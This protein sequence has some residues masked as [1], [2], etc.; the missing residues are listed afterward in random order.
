[1]APELHLG[2]QETYGLSVDIYALGMVFVELATRQKAAVCA[3]RS[4]R[5]CFA[6]DFDDVRQKMESA[7]TPGSFVEL[8]VQCLGY[9]DHE[10]PESE[11]V[12][13]WLEELVLE[14]D[15]QNKAATLEPA[16]AARTLGGGGESGESDSGSV[17]SAAAA[18]PLR[19]HFVQGSAGESETDELPKRDERGP[20]SSTSD[21]TDDDS[22]FAAA[23]DKP[24]PPKITLTLVDLQKKTSYGSD[25]D[26][27]DEKE[28][29]PS[30]P[31]TER[32]DD[33]LLDDEENAE[34]DAPERQNV[35]QRTKGAT[36]LALPAKVPP[37]P[38]PKSKGEEEEEAQQQVVVPPLAVPLEASEPS[39][40]EPLSSS[41][42]KA[43]AKTTFPQRNSK[44]LSKSSSTTT[45][46]RPPSIEHTRGSGRGLA[47]MAARRIHSLRE[48]GI[49]TTR[50]VGFLNKKTRTAFAA[51]YQRRWF[52][53]KSG[54]L[55]WFSQPGN[56]NALGRLALT[57]SHDLVATGKTKFAVYANPKS[58]P[59]KSPSKSSLLGGATKI[60]S[61]RRGEDK[62]KRSKPVLELA[63][64]DETNKDMWIQAL[65]TEINER[66]KAER[67]RTLASVLGG[68]DELFEVDGD[69]FVSRSQSGFLTPVP[70]S[71]P[72]SAP[73][74]S[75]SETRSSDHSRKQQHQ[76]RHD[77]GGGEV[78][79]ADNGLPKTSSSPTPPASSSTQRP[80]SSQRRL[81]VSSWMEMLRLPA[82]TAEQFQKAG[83]ANL[84]M[85]FE[86]GLTDE[87]LDYVGVEVPLHRR[88]LKAAAEE[89]T[90]AASLRSQ[91][92]DYRNSGQV[93]FYVI[94]SS[95][96][97]RR[98]TLHL[99]Y[100]NFVTLYAKLR[101]IER[102]RSQTSS[103]FAD[104]GDPLPKLP[105]SRVFIDAKGPLFLEQRRK[106]LD[107]YLQKT[108]N[109]ASNDQKLEQALLAF[110]DVGDVD[111]KHVT[112]RSTTQHNKHGGGG[113]MTTPTKS[114]P[115][116]ALPVD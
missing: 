75:L 108:I 13:A 19:N 65:Q 80:R 76:Q 57:S 51:R 40:S 81:D 33:D 111:A 70:S 53:L 16:N 3:P 116:C 35:W 48:V 68:D 88:V 55:L 44:R 97:F 37:P 41:S 60:P 73:S 24:P 79:V 30:S 5:D 7:C 84:A 8:A 78:V 90:F 91:V 52:V 96:K 112:L 114:S 12:G 67:A 94:R 105:G 72:D 18:P 31:L 56:A 43:Q 110:L 58:S 1:M 104:F 61:P 10:R 106:E 63:A 74:T 20:L 87:D 47:L 54:T 14:V 15:P 115:G 86:M 22:H 25:D 62:P 50:M 98:S 93:A 59:P 29:G 64:P 6:L 49:D 23:D 28:E 27:D 4:P 66:A 42:T 9:E 26:D 102:E 113:G 2:E 92:V 89:G 100:A 69:A 32:D 38:P 11:D 77:G 83:Y 107:E 36:P 39:L 71:P 99:R 45:T 21:R 82:S 95:Y 85:V 34:D 101:S 109:V 46:K 103:P 17:A